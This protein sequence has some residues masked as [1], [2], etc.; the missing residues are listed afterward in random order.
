MKID[1]ECKELEEIKEELRS[2]NH[3]RIIVDVLSR[4]MIYKLKHDR[5]KAKPIESRGG[6]MKGL[7]KLAN[8]TKSVDLNRETVPDSSGRSTFNP[9]LTAQ[10]A[11]ASENI[12]IPSYT[13]PVSIQLATNNAY[14]SSKGYRSSKQTVVR[15]VGNS[16][17]VPSMKRGHLP[18]EVRDLKTVTVDLTEYQSVKEKSKKRGNSP[19]NAKKTAIT[20]LTKAI[21]LK[22]NVA[23]TKLQRVQA[24]LEQATVRYDKERLLHRK[25]IKAIAQQIHEKYEEK[26]TNIQTALG[27]LV[28]D[29]L[30]KIERVASQRFNLMSQMVEDT[31]SST[32]TATVASTVADITN[33][34]NMRQSQEFLRLSQERDAE[35]ARKDA[36][37]ARKAIEKK[38]EHEKQARIRA[39]ERE[40]DLRYRDEILQAAAKLRSATTNQP[41][42]KVMT[43]RS[44]AITDDITTPAVVMKGKNKVDQGC[45]NDAP[46]ETV[47]VMHRS[48]NSA[49]KGMKKVDQGCG[50]DAPEV[51]TVDVNPQSTEA[52][53]DAKTQMESETEAT[54][55]MPSYNPRAGIENKKAS[56]ASNAQKVRPH[57]KRGT[58]TNQPASVASTNKPTTSQNKVTAN[59]RKRQP[60]QKQPMADKVTAPKAPTTVTTAVNN[61]TPVINELITIAL[62]PP[63]SS[64]PEGV[65][66]DDEGA[67]HTVKHKASHVDYNNQGFGTQYQLVG[68][69]TGLHWELKDNVTSYDDDDVVYPVRPPGISGGSAI[70]AHSVNEVIGEKTTREDDIGQQV[71]GV[72]HGLLN[73]V[74][75]ING[76]NLSSSFSSQQSISHPSEV[77]SGPMDDKLD[78]RFNHQQQQH[79]SLFGTDAYDVRPTSGNWMSRIVTADKKSIDTRAESTDAAPNSVAANVIDKNLML[80]L[81]TVVSTQQETIKG[82]QALISAMLEKEAREKEHFMQMQSQYTPPTEVRAAVSSVDAR[83]AA[84][85]L[86]LTAHSDDTV[87]HADASNVNTDVIDTAS[88]KVDESLE[89]WTAAKV[90]ADVNT[91]TSTNYPMYTYH[92]ASPSAAEIASAL[93]NAL[94]DVVQATVYNQ[95]APPPSVVP[96][97]SATEVSDAVTKGVEEGVRKALAEVKHTIGSNVGVVREEDSENRNTNIPACRFLLDGNKPKA[98][99][100]IQQ[101][102]VESRLKEEIIVS[103]RSVYGNSDSDSDSDSLSVDSSNEFFDKRRVGLYRK[104]ATTQSTTTKKKA[105][106]K[107]PTPLISSVLPHAATAMNVDCNDDLLHMSMDST[108][109]GLSDYIPTETYAG[110]PLPRRVKSLHTNTNAA[111]IDSDE[112][113]SVTG[114]DDGDEDSADNIQVPTILAVTK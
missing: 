69:H 67:V 87:A 48:Q 74:L 89:A 3:E 13:P 86:P 108:L 84:P 111:S 88:K 64:L 95:Q 90:K 53:L 63:V 39:M 37:K 106:F 82:N 65:D 52:A 66:D 19:S 80:L 102:T 12:P 41:L 11:D 2:I 25:Q 101:R 14:N 78:L 105:T 61:Q 85:T 109:D 75:V 46:E 40:Q 15:P 27:K 31:V 112:W 21:N 100:V 47:P 94:G 54:P 92:N 50:S 68:D 9:S 93:A 29:A 8:S 110:P 5:N 28:D 79:A 24:E 72:G 4:Q 114:S 42:Y 22:L 44:R 49:T 34:E 113:M 59:E 70:Y 36:E 76:V 58:T 56:Q 23:E 10:P 35:K 55:I 26:D 45:G 18:P 43:A 71:Y 32:V 16:I 81:E 60:V 51:G 73:E 38:R 30:S 62:Q 104:G 97:M 98:D 1:D 103:K 77:Q 7:T 91:N 99:Q 107:M 96:S 17:M 57:S 20:N 33:K 83:E 6:N